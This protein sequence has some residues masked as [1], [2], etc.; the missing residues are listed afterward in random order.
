MMRWG[1]SVGAHSARTTV[2]GGR[3]RRIGV[4]ATLS[5]VLLSS[6]SCGLTGEDSITITAHFTDSVGLFAGNNVDVLGVPVG[7]VTAVKPL[8][9][10]VEVKMRVPADMPIPA[11]AGALIIPPSVVTDRYVELTPAYTAGPTLVDGALIPLQ[12]TRTPV[13]FDRIVRAIDD[14][15]TSLNK[16]TSTTRA[17]RDALGVAAQNLRG[18]GLSVRQSV[19]GLSAAVGALAANRNDL[20]GL[21]RSL[22][23]LTATFAQNDATVRQFS[24]NITA[25]TSVL[26][27]NGAELD[28]TIAALTT[29]LTEVGDFV[30]TNKGL[31][32]S[33][34]VSLSQVLATLNSHQREVAEALDVLPLTFQ[35]LALMVD[36]RTRRIRSNASAAANLLNPVILKQFCHGV[37]LEPCP[38]IQRPSG[39]LAD[40][41]RRPSAPP[42]AP[43]PALA[44][45]GARR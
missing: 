11:T 18:N 40:V 25:A 39:A 33:G 16:D 3:L 22:D 43:A 2:V 32:R 14:L 30:R 4:L 42:W 35:N 8:G 10:R 45:K 19:E 38:E 31:A 41:F 6:A 20:I 27:S 36:P 17:I 34:V 21:I 29:A 23:T 1:K 9:D 28:A 44:P 7:R 37:G 5:T 24:K 12:R 26:A 15:A 13:E